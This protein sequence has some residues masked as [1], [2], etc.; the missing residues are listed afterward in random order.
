MLKHV[1]IRSLYTVVRADKYPRDIK[2]DF[3]SNQANHVFL[4]VPMEEDTIWLECTSQTSPFGY[5]GNFTDDR[6]VML[7]TEKGGKIVRSKG[8][9]KDQNRQATKATVTI[10]DGKSCIVD[11]KTVYSGLQY[12]N[13]SGRL[14]DS[15]E[16]N[17]R[18]LYNNLGLSNFKILSFDFRSIPDQPVAIAHQE[19][20]LA[21]YLSGSGSRVFVPLNMFNST[22][23]VPRREPGR[24]RDVVIRYPFTDIDSIRYVIPEGYTIE[25]IPS[26]SEI[27]TPFGEYR[28]N[29]KAEGNEVLYI[30]ERKM[31][32]GTFPPESYDQLREFFNEISRS[33][34]AKLVLLKGN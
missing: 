1:G 6:K 5:I 29:I 9:G 15:H 13:I 17:Q 34:R 31:N 12:D 22:S 14:H 11:V 20:E 21:S 27:V 2:E 8:Y 24:K 30:R 3:V 25:S 26:D 33:D 10:K 4:C 16:D 28:M 18:W 32:R 19:L 7:I 23:Y